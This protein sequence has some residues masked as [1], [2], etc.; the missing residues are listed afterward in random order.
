MNKIYIVINKYVKK[1]QKYLPIAFFIGG[2]LWDSLTLGRI[3]SLIDTILLFSYLVI[4]SIS[5]YMY[6]L[7]DDGKWIG[8]KIEKWTIYLPEVIQF[9]LGGLTSAFVIYFSRSVSFTRTVSFF[10][11]LIFV[12]I[13]NEFLKGRISNK[14]LQFS[15]YLFVSF[16][17]FSFFIPVILSDINTTIFIISGIISLICSFVL[18]FITYYT[19]PSTRKEIHI[20]K[21]SLLLVL[22]YLLI[23]VFY[24][25]S[26]IPPVP[27]ALEE[28]IVAYHVD[29]KQDK[30]EVKYE[31][32]DMF[33]FWRSYNDTVNWNPG[34]SIFIFSSIF[35]P[36][37]LKKPV[38][39]YWEQYD[40]ESKDWIVKDSIPFVI[41]GGR[42]NGYRG[43]T[44]KSN[45]VNGK[46]RVKVLTEEKLLLGTIKFIVV[47]NN[48]DNEVKTKTKEF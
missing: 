15:A 33:V 20:G 3:D 41:E 9:F 39:H 34:D 36:T 43:Y 21:I 24:Y 6:N 32:S 38:Y 18:V 11:I 23:N 12:L 30:Y 42:D 16:T 22:I 27:L 37:D 47:K 19:S 31:P 8:T 25:F 1:H 17:F 45:I 28:G 14:Y 46:W 10:V 2:F 48:L 40:L 26:L 44:Y 35:A 7:V 29:K 5:I 13:A 4:L